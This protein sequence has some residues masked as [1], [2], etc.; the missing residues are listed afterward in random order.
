MRGLK[1]ILSLLLQLE[2][3][4]YDF[5]NNEYV[6]IGKGSA[7]LSFLLPVNSL[8]IALYFHLN[9]VAY[10][11]RFEGPRNCE[12]HMRGLVSDKDPIEGII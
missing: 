2:V 3:E 5:V 4:A 8:N 9:L 6:Y 10:D 12:V 1:H 11:P 7:V